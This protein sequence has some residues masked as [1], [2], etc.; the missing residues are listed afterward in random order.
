MSA[1]SVVSSNRLLIEAMKGIRLRKRSTISG[2]PDVFI[3]LFWKLII[4]DGNGGAPKR[5]GSSEFRREKTVPYGAQGINS[6]I[7]VV[8]GARTLRGG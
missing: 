4:I 6:N 2:G 5:S 7:S 1:I 3:M 8:W